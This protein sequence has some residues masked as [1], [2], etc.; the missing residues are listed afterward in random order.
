[1]DTSSTIPMGTTVL[2]VCGLFLTLY[3]HI[4]KLCED[5]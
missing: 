3:M 1:M 2:V 4:I 5:V